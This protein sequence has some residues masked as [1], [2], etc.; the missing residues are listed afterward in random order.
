MAHFTILLG[1]SENGVPHPNLEDWR[2]VIEQ[3]IHIHEDGQGNIHYLVGQFESPRKARAYFESLIAQ[4]LEPIKY[5]PLVDDCIIPIGWEG[6]LVIG[7]KAREVEPRRD[8][9]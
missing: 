8:E 5:F 4:G 3:N 7:V 6:R 1:K 9:A 2:G